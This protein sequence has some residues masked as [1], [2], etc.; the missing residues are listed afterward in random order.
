MGPDSFQQILGEFK[1]Y[2]WNA[3]IKGFLGYLGE[4][5]FVRFF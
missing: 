4:F 5:W 1:M 3:K 2:E